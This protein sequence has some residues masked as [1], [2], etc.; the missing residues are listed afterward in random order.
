MKAPGHGNGEGSPGPVKRRRP[1]QGAV[2]QV[3]LIGFMASGKSTVGPILAR[4]L[5][6]RFVDLDQLIEERTRM[7]IPVI[8][9]VYGEDVFRLLEAVLT[10]EVA[11]RDRTVLAPGGGWVLRPEL[12]DELDRDA[13]VVWL[14]ITP[15][16]A[17]RRVRR[18]PANRPLLAAGDPLS[19]AAKL[20]SAREPYYRVASHVVDVDER[21]PEDIA[22]DIADKVMA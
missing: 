22:S 21:D 4:R 19:T 15:E 18:G 14:R 5:G 3:V 17:L 12:L 10:R 11:G 9:E 16:E 8:F 13:L 1:P 7:S 20:L 6:W 2:S